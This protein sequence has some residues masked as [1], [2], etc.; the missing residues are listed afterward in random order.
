METFL[1]LVEHYVHV[2]AELNEHVVLGEG[3]EALA[4]AHEALD[5]ASKIDA[6]VVRLEE[7]GSALPS[8]LSP[9]DG[10]YVETLQELKNSA[11]LMVHRE[12]VP[13]PFEDLGVDKER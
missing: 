12:Y 11:G 4:C 8:A 1:Q 2:W 3:K 7:R 6:E 10:Y 5:L 13:W 9:Y